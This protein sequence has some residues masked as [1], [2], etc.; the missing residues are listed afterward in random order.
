MT[1]VLGLAVAL[2]SLGWLLGTPFRLRWAM[3]GLLWLAVVVVNLALPAGHALR[4][5]TGGDVRV[6][7]VLAL[8]AG[9]GFGYRAVLLGLRARAAGSSGAWDRR[10]SAQA[11]WP[12]TRG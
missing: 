12:R 10:P 7:L 2:W 6:W 11:A 5:A 4:Q 3:I 8:V 9:L 1:L